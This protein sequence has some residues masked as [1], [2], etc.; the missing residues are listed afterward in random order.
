[1]T[2]R[3]ESNTTLI[4]IADRLGAAQRLLLT[5]H[6]KPDGDALG[7]IVALGLALRARDKAVELRVLPPRPANLAF[8]D[9]AMPVVLHEGPAA[10]HIDEPDLIVVTDTGAWSQL[11]PLRAFLEPRAERTIVID[12]HLHGDMVGTMQYVDATAAAACQ[13]VADLIDTLG[14]TFDHA[15][16]EALFVGIASDTGWF[17]FS[18]TRPATHELAARL[19]AAGV[20]HAALYARTE[21]GE[22]PEKL[23]LLNRAL[24]SMELIAD[25]RAAVL[26]L[27]LADF[28]Q[29]GARPDETERLV[30]V[31]Q[32]AR[33]VQVVALV[34]EHDGRQTRLSFRSKPTD[35]AIDV[36]ALARTFD[37]GGHA[38]AAGAKVDQPID[39]VRPRVIDAIR[40]AFGQANR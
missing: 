33:D 9:H 22:R 27:R 23:A 8:L 35:H 10:R 11:E 19:L 34:V 29:T 31:P 18:N 17:R 26:T 14:V 2:D 24:D 7:S 38:R 25:G 1:M 13:I 4:D 36:N 16:A 30:D 21:Q 32:I 15:I 40:H 5:T 20:D 3:Y 6:A 39:T 37:G 12:H 28:K